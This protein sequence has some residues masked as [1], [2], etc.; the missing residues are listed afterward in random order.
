MQEVI[1]SIPFTSTKISGS[2]FLADSLRRIFEVVFRG[3]VRR[4]RESTILP[5]KFQGFDPI[6]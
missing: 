3:F 5:G 6:V 2:G 1:G 4:M